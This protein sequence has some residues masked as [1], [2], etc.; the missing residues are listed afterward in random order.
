M[1]M[2]R[3]HDYLNLRPFHGFGDA[4]VPPDPD[5]G[6]IDGVPQSGLGIDL[7]NLP[8]CIQAPCGYQTP[9]PG[10]ASQALQL[11]PGAAPIVNDADF[12]SPMPNTAPTLLAAPAS[13]FKTS[14]IMWAALAGGAWYFFLR[15]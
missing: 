6:S 2:Y 14:W 11:W 10:I 5:A 7:T 8:Q 15:K 4:G 9:W 1:A 12:V 13:T 3:Q